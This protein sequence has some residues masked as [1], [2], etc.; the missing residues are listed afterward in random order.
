ME[1]SLPWDRLLD[2]V[3]LDASKATE[4]LKRWRQYTLPLLARPELGLDPEVQTKLL[5]YSTL[6]PSVVKDL[7]NER[8]RMATGAVVVASLRGTRMRDEPT[9]KEVEDLLE[10]IEA[11]HTEAH[12]AASPW[13]IKIER[14][15]ARANRRVGARGQKRTPRRTGS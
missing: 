14:K 13:L 4:E 3:K 7:R 9:D 12:G 8:R 10:T 6:S 11:H 5:A 1:T 15:A 2:F